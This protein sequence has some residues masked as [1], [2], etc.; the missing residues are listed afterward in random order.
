MQL[1]DKSLR[2]IINEHLWWE[3]FEESPEDAARLLEGVEDTSKEV[4]KISFLN[5]QEEGSLL[6]ESSFRKLD[7]Y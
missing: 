2:E 3:D 5:H 1:K 6:D 7:F 4:N